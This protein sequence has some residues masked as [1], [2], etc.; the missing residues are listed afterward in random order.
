[1]TQ[2]ARLL[3]SVQGVVVQATKDALSGSP[4][5]GKATII[6]GSGTS[7]ATPRGLDISGHRIN[8]K[9]YR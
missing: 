8:K 7:C 4:T 6:S 9:I 1:M 5:I 2:R 3:G